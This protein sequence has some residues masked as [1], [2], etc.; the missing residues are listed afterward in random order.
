M[1]TFYIRNRQLPFFFNVG[2]LAQLVSLHN[3]SH[4]D[5]QSPCHLPR[6]VLHVLLRQPGDPFAVPH[7][8]NRL[9]R[10]AGSFA[11][12]QLVARLVEAGRLVVDVGDVDVDLVG[13]LELSIGRSHRDGV[14]SEGRQTYTRGLHGWVVTGERGAMCSG[15]GT[16][17]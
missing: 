11:H 5:H 13:G 1:H 6:T 4:H 17:F 3:A 15:L 8:N 10:V 16:G 14:L 2:S 9:G 12:P 7:L